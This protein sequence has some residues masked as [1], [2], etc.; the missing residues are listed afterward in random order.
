MSVLCVCVIC[1]TRVH[2]F[3]VIWIC[4]TSALLRYEYVVSML[5]MRPYMRSP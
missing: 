2:S 4:S 1:V 5:C 3:N